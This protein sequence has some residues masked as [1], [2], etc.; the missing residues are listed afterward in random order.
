MSETTNRLS[1][2]VRERAVRL[3]LVTEGR[4][5]SGWQ[6]LVSISAKIGCSAHRLNDWVKQAEVDSGKRAGVPSALTE[7]M[8]ALEREN[9]ELRQG[10]EVR[11]TAR[12]TVFPTNEI[13][14]KGKASGGATGSS[15]LASAYFAMLC[16][17][18][19]GPYE[20][21]VFG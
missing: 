15:P 2:E 6:A 21:G 20:A 9:R 17:P 13:L 4:H 14:R 8:K 7:R 3:V 5:G 12:G 10:E 1:P 18:E 19:T 11:K 16:R